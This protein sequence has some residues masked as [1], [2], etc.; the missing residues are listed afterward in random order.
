M[1]TLK[2]NSFIIFSLS[3]FWIIAQSARADLPGDDKDVARVRDA[4]IAATS[5]RAGELPI[6]TPWKCTELVAI[7][8]IPNASPEIHDN[9]LNFYEM[10]I[11]GYIGN[12]GKAPSKLFTFMEAYLTGAFQVTKFGR[13]KIF[14]YFIRRV[15]K[16]TLYI[17]WTIDQ[18]TTLSSERKA[19]VKSAVSDEYYVESYFECGLSE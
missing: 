8:G 13:Q 7:K 16:D 11:P 18:N 12:T 19:R 1:R 3:L 17:E 9:F 2:K 4:F 10:K 6:N 14:R 5:P 15:N